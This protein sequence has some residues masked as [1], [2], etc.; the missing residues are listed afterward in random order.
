MEEL[1][2]A[3]WLNGEL[4]SQ[5]E[6]EMELTCA[7]NR[8]ESVWASHAQRRSMALGGRKS[9]LPAVTDAPRKSIL[10]KSVAS[11]NDSPTY[12][13]QPSTSRASTQADDDHE[14]SNKRKSS[15]IAFVS[16]QEMKSP[17]QLRRKFDEEQTAGAMHK[18]EIFHDDKESAVRD[19]KDLF[20][21]PN[22]PPVSR[23]RVSSA[24]DLGDDNEGC[25]TQ[26]FNFFIKSQSVSTPKANSKSAQCLSSSDIQ[27]RSDLFAENEPSTS[28]AVRQPFTS[29]MPSEDESS[30]NYPSPELE[31]NRHK[32]SAILETTEDTNTISSAATIS[33]KS[34]S[35]DELRTICEANS[36]VDSITS[37]TVASANKTPPLA[38]I[39][40][41]RIVDKLVEV[42]PKAQQ[43]GPSQEADKNQSI[44]ECKATKTAEASVA[45]V[46]PFDI[47]EDNS[48]HFADNHSVSKAA[49]EEPPSVCPLNLIE[50]RTETIPPFLMNRNQT[51]EANS[52]M[53]LAE[54]TIQIPLPIDESMKLPSTMIPMISD[55]SQFAIFEDEAVVLSYPDCK[56]KLKDN[57]TIDKSVFNF[58]ND[59]SVMPPPEPLSTTVMSTELTDLVQ[60]MNLSSKSTLLP[61][62]SIVDRSEFN[63]FQDEN[64]RSM[65][66]PV[67]DEVSSMSMFAIASAVQSN[68]ETNDTQLQM[69]DKNESQR[70]AISS[71]NV[72][73]LAAAVS[74]PKISCAKTDIDDEFY[75]MMQSPDTRFPKSVA[76]PPK[77]SI[78]DESYEKESV[79]NDHSISLLR[80]MKEISINEHQRVDRSAVPM[81]AQLMN[82]A[83]AEFTFSEE[84]PNTELFSVHLGSIKNSTLLERGPSPMPSITNQPKSDAK[85]EVASNGSQETKNV[86]SLDDEFYAMIRSPVPPTRSK[87]L[88]QATQQV[89]EGPNENKCSSFDDKFYALINS[90]ILPMAQAS[91]SKVTSSQTN[92]FFEISGVE[93]N[94]AEMK[95]MRKGRAECASDLSFP[96]I[97]MS[98]PKT[99][100]PSEFNRMTAHFTILDSPEASV[101]KA[102]P[103]NIGLCK[104]VIDDSSVLIVDPTEDLSAIVQ[105]CPKEQSNVNESGASFRRRNQ[106]MYERKGNVSI[107]YSQSQQ[108]DPFNIDVQH[109]FLSDIDF[110]DYISKLDNVYMVNRAR[111]LQ[112]NTEIAFGDKEFHIIQQIGQGSFGFVY[113]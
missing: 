66:P 69:S 28:T 29:R 52:I 25:T 70:A 37:T 63:I 5:R 109:A 81:Q 3:R 79:A 11:S 55:R 38:T 48:L 49:H 16:D 91:F 104:R 20:K 99:I 96:K 17:P 101:H 36:N 108:I 77:I 89:N 58:I 92:S 19:D 2:Q 82:P 13:V 68:S 88:N 33:S 113:R 41:M 10:R 7:F 50:D 80:P 103:S 62:A 61:R 40:E 23:P 39:D 94:E 18:F 105:Q 34:S 87:S 110:V 78:V 64:D 86:T 45:S 32:L 1:L 42:S 75:R 106:S 84:N 59:Q 44:N 12:S 51:I 15:K 53:P 102:E 97:Q 22:P 65:A 47:Y 43:P 74:L 56:Q 24:F 14:A 93:L 67:P 83:R 31:T 76:V 26:T 98:A 35:V 71:E 30:A 72:L 111:A 60:K 57:E 9:I 4:V 100:R 73:G 54:P 27:P 85:A 21:A 107:D 46:L 8:R 95:L 112:P 6:S 90:P